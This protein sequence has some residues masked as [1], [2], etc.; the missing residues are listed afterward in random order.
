MQWR[1]TTYTAA[2]ISS[3]VSVASPQLS[4]AMRLR[5]QP[6][7]DEVCSRRAAALRQ[8]LKAT[9]AQPAKHEGIRHIQDIFQQ[10][11]QRMFAW[12]DDRAIPADNNLA[13]WDLRPLVIA[14]RVSFGSI[15]DGGKGEKHFDHGCGDHSEAGR[16]REG[17][18]QGSV[19]SLGPQPESRPL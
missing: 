11:E 19:G 12:A 15:T 9:M 5:G 16:E 17:L 1:C 10:N 6:I 4:L 13:K 14:R 2:E 3:C 8:K 18:N 7:F